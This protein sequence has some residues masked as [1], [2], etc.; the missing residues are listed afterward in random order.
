VGGA[1]EVSG[2][3]ARARRDSA[4][5]LPSEVIGFARSGEPD[6][7][8]FRHRVRGPFWDVLAAARVTLLVTR[9]YEHLILSLGTRGGRPDVTAL[10]VPHPSGLAVN[11]LTGT[12]HV[13]LT[14]NPNVVLDLQ[15]AD[16]LLARRDLA[17]RP[18][19]RGTLV[20]VHARFYPGSFY[21][22]DLAFVGG[23][24]HG[25]AVGRNGVIRLGPGDDTRLAW[26]PRAVERR[27]RPRED[28]NYLQLNS[29]AGGDDLGS[30]FFTASAERPSSRFPGQRNFPVDGRGVLLSGATREPVAGGLT[31]PHSARLHQG[32]VW[33]DNS[34]Y[35]ELRR[36]SGAWEVV[37]RLPGWTR[38]LC[39]AGDMAFVGTSRILPRFAAYAPGLKARASV[40]AVH[41]VDLRTG[42]IVASL[43]WPSG[44]QIFAIEAVASSR[45]YALPFGSPPE[46][47]GRRERALFYA[48]RMKDSDV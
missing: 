6:R 4:W 39:F 27:G 3:S 22:H 19:V 33:V 23:V 43:H 21:L 10:P 28:R 38:G 36:W 8:S 34:G 37:A 20:P 9:E 24:L 35:G 44:D 15:P 16:G 29:I 7:E 26:W 40:C 1:P 48:F 46:R 25:N 47:S 42:S 12:V 32:H 5:R 13:A 14:R 30:S 17:V 18:D 31:R 41:A 2:G 45:R 11:P